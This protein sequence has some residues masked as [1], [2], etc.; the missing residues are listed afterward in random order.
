MERIGNLFFKTRNFLFPVFYAILFL[1]FPRISKNYIVMFI[2][3]FVITIFGQLVRMITIGLVYIVRGGKNRRIYA[4][5]LVTDGIFSHSRNPMYIGNV[6]MI[7]GMSILSNS[8]FALLIMVPLFVFIY[9]TIIIAEENYLHTKFGSGYN[10][11]CKKVN[12]WLPDLHGIT[13]TF[14]DN[15]FDVKKVLMNEYNTTFLWMF[16]GILLFAY[17]YY[18]NRFSEISI[19]GLTYFIVVL[20][21][22]IAAYFVLRSYKK[23]KTKSLKLKV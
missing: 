7:A 17:N 5:G 15:G 23:R 9:Q 19:E 12:R 22:L 6:L 3:G 16:G 4:D 14:R 20:T 13:K 11:Y 18:W 8:I 1:P 10:E 21:I 2:I